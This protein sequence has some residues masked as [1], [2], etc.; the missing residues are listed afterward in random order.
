[1]DAV[2]P[3]A[4]IGPVRKLRLLAPVAAA[5]ALVPLAVRVHYPMDFGLAY[6][7]GL[8]AW[9]SGHPEP[10]GTWT[11]T[12]FLGLVMAAITQVATLEAATLVMLAANLVVW[13]G[14][15]LAV[16]SRLQDLVP[17][18]WWWGTL[19]SAAVFAPAISNIFWMQPNLIVLALALGGVALM[20]RR[21][22]AAGL[23]IGTALALKP[24]LILLPFAFLL[25]RASRRAGAWAIVV[26][27]ALSA[28]GL[29]FLAWRAGDLSVSNPIAYLAQFLTKGRGP[30]YACVPEN[31][32]PLALLCRFG[33]PAS[34]TLTVAVA[35]VVL[36]AGWLVTRRLRDAPDARWELFAAAGLLSPMLG[37]IGWAVYQVLL[38]PLMLLLAYQFWT[39]RAPVFLWVNLGGVFLLTMLIWDP[40]ESLALTPVPLL[41]VSYTL[42][43][44]AQ[45]YLLLLW[46]QWMRMRSAKATN[47]ARTVIGAHAG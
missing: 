6:H 34:T 16:W 22:L 14:L 10:L 17:S 7:A 25:H 44:F 23:L 1:V 32:S 18:R 41:V 39:Y 42:G 38:A 8:L 47:A 3:V 31:Y 13:G 43:Q 29:G 26:A 12:P 45:Y 19:A 4:A 21:N 24:I 11:G 15:L 46:V 33:V 30:D 28:I 5:L 40:L 9:S 27:A 36:I 35:G 2:Q 20:G 37:P